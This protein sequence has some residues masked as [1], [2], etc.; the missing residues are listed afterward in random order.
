MNIIIPVGGVGKRFTDAGYTISKPMIQ[1]GKKKIIE[2]L[3]DCIK[4]Y[5]N[6]NDDVFIIYQPLLESMKEYLLQKYTFLNMIKL[7]EFT[8]GPVETLYNGMNKIRHNVRHKKTIL[9]DCDT[10]YVKNIFNEIYTKNENG[11]FFFQEEYCHLKQFSYIKLSNQWISD[12]KEKQDI[13]NNACTGA[14]FFKD[15]D[16]LL[17]YSK[18]IIEMDKRFK[19]E[20]Y[21]SCLIDEMMKDK[22]EFIAVE[23]EQSDVI[24]LGTPTQIHAFQQDLFLFCFDLDGT[25]VNTDE[26]YFKIWKQLLPHIDVNSEI[27]KR[28]ILG[29]DDSTVLYKLN[30]ITSNDKIESISQ[31][32]DE[33]FIHL[34]HH[35]K[36]IEGAREFLQKLFLLGHHVNF[37]IIWL[38]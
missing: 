29:N 30:N 31:K 36:V 2:Y 7:N 19:N 5:K 10:F 38:P 15:I 6:E 12:I 3:L 33:L 4:L 28:Y 14:Y 13:S 23:L 25:L 26:I 17:R 32:K 8:N 20:Y 21:V 34:I 1:I 27:Y 24:F 16:E 18:K 22:H 35:V 11:V 37:I 9:L